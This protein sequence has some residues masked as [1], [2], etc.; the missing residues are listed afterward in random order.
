MQQI[1]HDKCLQPFGL[2]ECNFLMSLFGYILKILS[3][4]IRKIECVNLI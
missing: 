1:G 4:K 2:G 3:N